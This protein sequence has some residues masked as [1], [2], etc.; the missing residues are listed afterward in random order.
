M[1]DPTLLLKRLQDF[2]FLRGLTKAGLIEV[3]KQHI[4]ILNRAGLAERA[5][6]QGD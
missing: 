6:L 1:T 4:R 3:D 5:M 2:D